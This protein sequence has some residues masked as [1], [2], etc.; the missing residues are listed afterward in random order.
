MGPRRCSVLV[1]D[2]SA[3]MRR[4]VTS[5]IE[6]DP[7]LT[8]VGTARNGVEAVERVIAL[9]PDVVTLDVEMPGMNGF[10]AL[11]A[12]MA[13]RPTPVLMVSS[14]TMEGA[15]ATIK[16]LELGAVDFFPKPSAALSYDTDAISAE[17]T[18]K[19]RAAA[20]TTIGRRAAVTPIVPML[21]AASG[22]GVRPK[23]VFI[24]SSTGGPKALTSVIPRL[25][26]DLGV[27]VVVVQHMPAGFTKAL[28]SRLD[29][30]SALRVVE[31]ERG[32]RL[33]PNT[34]YIAPGW[35]HLEFSPTGQVLITDG[36]AVNGVKPAADVTLASLC[37]LYGPAICGVV[38][39]GMGKDGAMALKHLRGLGGW[40][41]AESEETC[42]VYGMP[43]AAVQCGAIEVVAPLEEIA[44]EI[45][46]ST[47]ALSRKIG[48]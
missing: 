40:T 31:A 4:I 32:M 1:V 43:R 38:L 42:V 16:C 20:A 6:T 10:E 8:V 22:P 36:P 11:E 30:S 27:P 44:N 9:R 24:A 12:I 29:S 28:A 19:I 48:A 25:P 41:I 45:V 23:C 3:F 39:T 17:L 7:T 33:Q 14:L 21:G 47:R 37:D 2:D 5:T 46:K 15:D 34:A 26:G 18:A 13:K 35:C